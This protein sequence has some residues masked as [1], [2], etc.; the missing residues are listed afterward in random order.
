MTEPR[1]LP[2]RTR[3]VVY[4]DGT[5]GRTLQVYCPT[6]G[7]SI[8]PRRCATCPR[9]HLLWADAVECSPAIE[10]DAPVEAFVSTTLTCVRD[11]V[12]VS[13]LATIPRSEPWFLPVVDAGVRFI[14]FVWSGDLLQV[15]VPAALL[16]AHNLVRASSLAVA[17]SAPVAHVVRWMGQ[18]RARAVALL[19]SRGTPTGVLTD[20]EALRALA[21]TRLA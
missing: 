10:N 8:A 20:V 14:G 7:Q 16:V 5:R 2:V 3:E 11:D 19:D 12:R 1:H 15:R 17:E 9:L 21:V 13:L 4:A 6:M 18:R